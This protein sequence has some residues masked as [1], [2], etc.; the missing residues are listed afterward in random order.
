MKP[1]KDYYNLLGKP[2][3]ERKPHYFWRIFII[4][5]ILIVLGLISLLGYYLYQINTPASQAEGQKVI[6]IAP[7]STSEAI[8]SQLKTAGLIRDERIFLLYVK[9]GPAHGLLKPGPYALKSNMTTVQIVDY[10]NSGKIA[11]KTI[12]FPEGLTIK[13]MA[14]RYEK[15][16]FGTKS[17]FIDATK[18]HYDFKFLAERPAGS[19]LEGY[20]FPD[21][22]TIKI[23]ASA[24]D[25]V[26]Q[27][28]TTF[29]TKAWSQ[30]SNTQ[31]QKYSSYQLLTLASVVEHEGLTDKDRA[32]IAGVFFNRL[33][34]GMKLESDVTISY[35][36]ERKQVTAAD[37]QKISPYNSYKT[38]GLPP[39]PIC[40]PGL[41]AIRAVAEPTASDYLYFLAD[42]QNK[43]YFAK[44][45]AEHQDNISKYLQ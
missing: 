23:N 45:Y 24:Q 36:T 32:M 26:T 27:M 39:S 18:Q 19:S 13:Q 22:Y 15:A 6:E 5:L 44:T 35:V 33:S 41:S 16:E 25:L 30:L 7:G 38:A 40:N 34:R 43:V 3:A 29:E 11:V 8:A 2:D 10:L 42:N 20:L 37:L 9:I 1:A 4:V 17:E 21:T 28:L 14:A 12:T 31:V